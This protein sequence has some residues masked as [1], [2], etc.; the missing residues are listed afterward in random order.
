MASYKREWIDNMFSEISQCSISISKTITQKEWKKLYKEMLPLA[1]KLD[2]GY[3][4]KFNFEGVEG[5]CISRAAEVINEEGIFC[6]TQEP[7]LKLEGVYSQRSIISQSYIDTNLREEWCEKDIGSA[8]L[9]YAYSD[10]SLST[11]MLGEEIEDTAYTESILALAFYMEAKLPEKIFVYGNFQYEYAVKAVNK[12]NE[13]LKKPIRLP[14]ICRPKDLMLQT[15]ETNFSDKKQF[16]FFYK[17]YMGKT[18]AEYWELLHDNFSD[19]IINTVIKSNGNEEENHNPQKFISNDVKADKSTDSNDEN[20]ELQY[21]IELSVQLF[22]FKKGNSIN[23]DLLKDIITVLHNVEPAKQ[24][25][26]FSLLSQHTPLE[27][28]SGLARHA[29]SL[30]LLDDDWKHIIHNFKT[31][32]NSLERYY[33]L[34]MVSC[35]TYG[36][37]S[38]IVRALI[39]NDTL[40]SYCISI[41]KGK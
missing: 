7:K 10:H 37:L 15:K 22:N 21:D 14:L 41:Q 31:N 8:F 40:Y 5:Y 28:I 36:T 4:R 20:T 27:Q 34:F 16:E 35:D 39:V 1:K 11:I 25:K 17:T 26:G 24:Q 29:K 30:L 13:F 3:L 6:P 19:E 38:N 32:N 12:I 18:D 2:L 23:P 33:P 9:G